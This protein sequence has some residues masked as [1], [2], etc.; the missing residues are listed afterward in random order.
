MAEVSIP[1][2][3]IWRR[4]HSLMG[5]WLVLFLCEH[6][7]TNSQAALWLGDDGKGFVSMVNTIHN[8]PY[9]QVIELTLI[10]IPILIHMVWGIQYALSAKSNAKKSDG[11]T[12]SLKKY[13]RNRAYSWQ[14]IT[15][16][17][18]LV[19]LLFHVTKFRFLEYPH[20]VSQGTETAYFVNLD[21]DEGLYS[22]A[23][24]LG[25]KLYDQKAIDEEA[26]SF[27][28]RIDER[29]LLE[30]A[31]TVKDEQFTWKEGV[32]ST[33]F[34]IQ[35]EI[36]LQSAEK[37]SLKE[38][39]VKALTAMQPGPKQVVAESSS[40]GTVTLLSVRDAFKN[41]L[42]IF[43]YTIFVL[44]ACF[45]AFNG[46]WTF[47]LSWGFIIRKAAQKS[48]LAFSLGLMFILSFLGLAAIWGTWFNL[49]N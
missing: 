44:A 18:L 46:F 35:K 29:D 7:L 31:K 6:L 9:L 3:F 21:M 5:L 33:D 1:K 15:S 26:S 49:R 42:Y 32:V 45:H 43:F 13:G 47:L 17:I 40:F 41:P 12:P 25:V 36:I 4:L 22:L 19:G 10:G 37:Y 2:A 20:Q 23:Y 48:L 27:N 39:W 24:R 34:A 14:R 30:A 38:A 16:W 28:L 11:S 8:F